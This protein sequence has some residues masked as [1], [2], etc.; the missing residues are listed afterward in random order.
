MMATSTTAG[1]NVNHDVMRIGFEVLEII[2]LYNK[3]L[4]TRTNDYRRIED[5]GLQLN[6]KC[7]YL[8]QS[9]SF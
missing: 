8:M 5:L 7:Q 4:Q 6:I 9:E 2:F 3:K 1:R